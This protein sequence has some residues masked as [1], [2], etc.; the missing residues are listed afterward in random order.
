MNSF[1]PIM[2]KERVI[3]EILINLKAGIKH[4]GFFNSANEKYKNL[5]RTI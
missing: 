1:T 3:K 4:T 5:N 2:W